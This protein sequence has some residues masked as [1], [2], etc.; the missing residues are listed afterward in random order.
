MT[1]FRSINE[2]L[3]EMIDKQERAM[4]RSDGVEPKGQLRFLQCFTAPAL[5]DISD[6]TKKA[7]A[8]FADEDN[9]GFALCGSHAPQE[10]TDALPAHA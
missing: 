10:N 6:C 2:I 7:V 9:R 1:G 4:N 8:Y 5:C 3:G